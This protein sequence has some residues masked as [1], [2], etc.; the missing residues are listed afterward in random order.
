MDNNENKRP[1]MSKAE[2]AR[3]LGVDINANDYE[4]ESAY[5]RKNMAMRGQVTAESAEFNRQI[6]E[7][8]DVCLLYTSDAADEQ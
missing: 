3:V 5:T 4:I 6:N 1:R 7:A 8:Y 2:A